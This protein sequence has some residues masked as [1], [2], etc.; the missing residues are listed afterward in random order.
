MSSPRIAFFCASFLEPEMWHIYRQIKALNNTFVLC[1]KRKNEADFPFDGL[2]VIPRSNLR[3]VGRFMEDI[4]GAPW[5]IGGGEVQKI[6]TILEEEKAQ[7]LHVFFG[8]VAIHLLPLLRKCPIPI[9]V[10]FHGA[11]VAGGRMTSAGREALTEVFTLAERV[12]CRSEAL[13]RDLIDLGCPSNKIR[14]LRTIIPQVEGELPRFPE[15][16]AWR[17]LQ[18]CRL[19]EKKGVDASLWAF[20]KFANTHPDAEFTIAGEG[21]KKER[22][23]KLATELGIAEKVKWVGFLSQSALQD[24]L[25]RTHLFLH[26]SKTTGDGDREGIPNAMLEAM[27]AGVPVLATEHG[28][29]PE[30]VTN[31][32]EG[33]LVPEGDI[34]QLSAALE[35]LTADPVRYSEMSRA[36]FDRIHREFSTEAQTANLEKIYSELLP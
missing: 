17:L 34:P 23:E 30:A 28:G 27:A 35:K 18:A 7:I 10:S 11:D 2:H 20:A 22:L 6:L 15:N 13:R 9:V 26:P 4:I 14:L 8:N 5:Q 3:F 31:G 1:Q 36:A 33:F 25:R 19:I 32:S 29:I 24:T 16:G 12:G 21:P